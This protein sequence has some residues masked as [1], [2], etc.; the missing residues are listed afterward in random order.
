M[1]SK[2]ESTKRVVEVFS[3]AELAPAQI[4]GE[5]EKLALSMKKVLSSRLSLRTVALLIW[6]SLPR[7]G[8][9]KRETIEEILKAAAHLDHYL[10]PDK[11]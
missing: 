9:P 11:K 1:A 5:V 10:V 2:E 3:E 7:K 8:R 4:A 6:D